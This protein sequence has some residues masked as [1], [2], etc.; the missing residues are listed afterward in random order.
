M[1]FT[2]AATLRVGFREPPIETESAFS[3]GEPVVELSGGHDLFVSNPRDV[4]Q[5]IDAF[6][7]SL[8]T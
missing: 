3:E 5:Q 6:V 7:A 2:A 8:Q 4:L 1:P